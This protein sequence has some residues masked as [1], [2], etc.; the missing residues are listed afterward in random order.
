MGLLLRWWW[1]TGKKDLIL[2][3]SVELHEEQREEGIVGSPLTCTCT[4]TSKTLC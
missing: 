1:L 3:V 4:E 2:M